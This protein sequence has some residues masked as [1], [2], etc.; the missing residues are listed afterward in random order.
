MTINY[1]Y[2]DAGFYVGQ[3]LAQIDPVASAVDNRT[4]YLLPR[5]AT[6]TAPPEG[7]TLEVNQKWQWVHAAWVIYTEPESEEE[8]GEA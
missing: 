6:W 8:M 4:H 3:S 1:N 7:I 5:N 2:D